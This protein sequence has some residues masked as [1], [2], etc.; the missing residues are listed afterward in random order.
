MSEE[1]VY[2]IVTVPPAAADES[3]AEMSQ[4]QFRQMQARTF[5]KLERKTASRQCDLAEVY[6]FEIPSL[7]VGTLDS[8]MVRPASIG[9]FLC[10][11]HAFDFSL[12]VTSSSKSTLRWR[13]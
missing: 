3:R 1:T 12:S 5:E 2:W 7:L 4:E 13:T 11:T 10:C 6:K 8:L 9:S